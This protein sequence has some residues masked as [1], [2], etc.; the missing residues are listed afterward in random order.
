MLKFVVFVFSTLIV[1]PASIEAKLLDPGGSLKIIS[2]ISGAT[3]TKFFPV[4][5]SIPFTI[6]SDLKSLRLSIS[7]GFWPSITY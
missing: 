4:V 2:G 3:V 7:K 1:V 5:L 6:P